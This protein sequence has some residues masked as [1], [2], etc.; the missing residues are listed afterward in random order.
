MAVRKLTIR[1]Y[2]GDDEYSWAVFYASDVK[3]LG[4][5]PITSYSVKPIVSG[6]SR[7]EANNHKGKLE[8]DMMNKL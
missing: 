4:R 6:C 5:G 8:H 3:G 7:R 2:M 1:K